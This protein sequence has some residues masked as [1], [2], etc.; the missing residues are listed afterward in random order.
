MALEVKFD[1]TDSIRFQANLLR[2]G[3]LPQKVVNKAAGKGAT[4][5]GKAVR[6]AAPRGKTKQLSKGFKRK[7]ERTKVKGRKAY[8]YAMDEAKNDI[9]QKPIPANP[10]HPGSRKKNWKHAYYPASIE[11]GF[12][13]RSK[14]GGM[15]YV[16]G[17]HF[18]RDAA[19]RVRPQVNRIVIKTL[20]DELD[21][22]W[23]KK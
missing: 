7:P 14:G 8:Y 5:A 23:R 17:T 10:S 6:A 18:A 1:F 12:L 20:T 22:E 11:Y 3:K 13:T 4:V 16:K 2:L 19:E 9:F 21:K 15:E